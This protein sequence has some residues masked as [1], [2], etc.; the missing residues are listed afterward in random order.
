MITSLVI[1]KSHNERPNKS[2]FI[3]AT[4][5]RLDF[6]QM[7]IDYHNKLVSYQLKKLPN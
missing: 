6:P 1:F 7:G 5:A 3:T 4:A 2:P